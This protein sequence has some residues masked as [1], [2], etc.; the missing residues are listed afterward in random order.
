MKQVANR[1]GLRTPSMH[2]LAPGA[3]AAPPEK[4][5]LLSVPEPISFNLSAD[6]VDPPCA[7]GNG[8]ESPQAVDGA[9]AATGKAAGASPPADAAALVGVASGAVGGARPPRRK[10]IYY[11]EVGVAALFFAMALY[12]AWQHARWQFAVFL[13]LQGVVFLLFGLNMVD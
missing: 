12:G 5:P 1:T 2:R 13:G 3:A 7:A 9:D 8:K 11:R 4:E 6:R 10:T